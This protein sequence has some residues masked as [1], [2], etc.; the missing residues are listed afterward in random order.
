M[1]NANTVGK[2]LNSICNDLALTFYIDS[3]SPAAAYQNSSI[4]H[5]SIVLAL[6]NSWDNG[7]SY[8]NYLTKLVRHTKLNGA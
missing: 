2:C 1:E 3:S 5:R 7:F 6:L 8:C 4:P